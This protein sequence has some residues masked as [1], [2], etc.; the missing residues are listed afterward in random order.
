M[1]CLSRLRKQ[2]IFYFSQHALRAGVVLD[3]RLLK[4]REET[5]K[6]KLTCSKS[7][8]IWN[9]NHWSINFLSG[10]KEVIIQAHFA[11][12]GFDVFYSYVFSLLK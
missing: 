4:E 8:D 5:N 3:G 6:Q 11:S 2:T 1:G 9:R 10:S 7:I 12:E